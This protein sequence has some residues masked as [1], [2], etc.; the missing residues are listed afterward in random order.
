MSSKCL[1]KIV[2][3]LWTTPIYKLKQLWYIP[4][5]SK[6]L[7]RDNEIRALYKQGFTLRKLAELYK[8]TFQRIHQIVKE[9]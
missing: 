9:R 5:M 7:K 1:V 8:L 4:D 3:R 2:H 6:E